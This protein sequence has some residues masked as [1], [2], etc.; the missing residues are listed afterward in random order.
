MTRN[1][2]NVADYLE[3][4]G[5]STT[6]DGDLDTAILT[7][8]KQ[9]TRSS[10]RSKSRPKSRG[11]SRAPS[12]TRSSRGSSRAPSRSR[13]SKSVSSRQK[14][15][16]TQK[17]K[18]SSSSRKKKGSRTKYTH[19]K[20]MGKNATLDSTFDMSIMSDVDYSEDDMWTL[21]SAKS[22]WTHATGY[23]E[24]YA[25]KDLESL[26]LTSD[27]DIM[28]QR[29]GTACFI[30]TIIQ[31]LVF[32]MMLSFCGIAP[33]GVNFGVGPYPDT[34]SHFGATNPYLFEVDQE[35]W[36][37][38]TSSF[39]PASLLH[40]FFNSLIQLE[41]GAYLEK[42][43]GTKRWLM[44]YLFSA[45]GSVGFSCAIVPTDVTVCMTGSLAGLLGA[46]LSEFIKIFCLTTRKKYSDDHYYQQSVIVTGVSLFLVL[47]SAMHPSLSVAGCVGGFLYGFAIGMWLLSGS[48][49][50]L[51]EKVTW[52]GFGFIMTGLLSMT[53]ISMVK[54]STAPEELENVCSFYEE[55]HEET[56]DCMCGY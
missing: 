53:V 49:I 2:D 45:V 18:Q 54:E 52:M 50:E 8:K 19:K 35:Y 34:L 51:V 39:L 28:T 6:S 29:Y 55:I 17:E 43:W 33:Y 7:G 41:F 38:L 15:L 40:F 22:N 26:L 24:R 3:A 27:I 37:L 1:S 4:G 31:L 30:I 25:A 48:I 44:I 36:R 20:G 42:E 47:M 11:S 46:R 12:R 16:N 21:H 32:S 9:R 56:Y 10:A 13:S 5:V 14:S 23:T